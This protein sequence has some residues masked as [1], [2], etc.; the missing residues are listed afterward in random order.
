MTNTMP[1]RRTIRHLAQRFRI[2][3]ETFITT[4]L[5]NF[6]SQCSQGF[7]YTRSSFIRLD[8]TQCCGPIGADHGT[9]RMRGSPSVT[10]TECSKWAVNDPSAET[11][12][13]WSGRTRVS[14]VPTSTMGS[15]AMVMPAL[16]GNP[17]PGLP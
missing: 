8:Y 11:T 13:H 14:S 2:D 16:S 4:L 1:L 15:R 3:G 17:V 9:V 5:T 10:A 12:V 7:D 6:H